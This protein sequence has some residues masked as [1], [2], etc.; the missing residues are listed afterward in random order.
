[1]PFPI[2]FLDIVYPGNIIDNKQPEGSFG[3]WVAVYFPLSSTSYK[4]NLRE[5]VKVSIKA[6]CSG[7]LCIYKFSIIRKYFNPFWDLK[8][9][10]LQFVIAGGT[11]FKS[12]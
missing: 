5:C 12:K 8:E 11:L 3:F 4:H 6:S 10:I 7:K 2:Y 1:M 9:Y